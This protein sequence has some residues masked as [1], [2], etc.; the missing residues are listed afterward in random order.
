[1]NKG[2]GSP[3]SQTSDCKKMS[4]LGFV[5]ENKLCT[6]KSNAYFNESECSESFIVYNI[7]CITFSLSSQKKL[8][9]KML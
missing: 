4:D 1:M 5:C 8:R 9:S 3:C 2:F 7:E 6:C